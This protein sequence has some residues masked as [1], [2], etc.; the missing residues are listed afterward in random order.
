MFTNKVQIRTKGLTMIE[1][2]VFILIIGVALGAILS[3]MRMTTTSATDPI[4]D[5]QALSIAESLLEAIQLQALTFCDPE[6]ANA[7]TATSSTGC[8][9][10]VQGLAPTAGESRYFEPRF[11][12]VGDYNGFSMS[13]IKDVENNVI[14]GLE[15]Y[16]ATVTESLHPD[17]VGVQ[18]NVRVTAGATDV[19]LTGYRYPYAPRTV[20]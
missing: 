5:K 8:A 12:N 1:M 17:G 6:D 4:R 14:S 16:T 9:T 3:V 10:T 11:D 15:I 18:I 7:G 2:I 19:L 20:P 13:G